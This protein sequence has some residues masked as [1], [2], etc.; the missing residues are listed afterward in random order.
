[1]RSIGDRQAILSALDGGDL[2]RV[3]LEEAT[4][5]PERQWHTLLETLIADGEVQRTGAG[6]KGSPYR[7]KLLRTDSAQTP[8]QLRAE[9]EHSDAR[10]SAAHP[11]R[12]QQKAASEATGPN[13]A[14]AQ[15]GNEGLPDGWTDDQLQSLVEGF[16]EVAS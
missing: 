9:T 7:F 5:A 1:M 13:A 4:G 16:E 14:H 6:K 12:V 3:E 2:T 11:V 15:N 8:V 10:F